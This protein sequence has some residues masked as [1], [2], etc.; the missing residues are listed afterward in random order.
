MLMED[1]FI[2][3]KHRGLE[4]V[5]GGAL[6]EDDIVY[7][8]HAQI[9]AGQET[10]YLG[11]L[12]A[13]TKHHVPMLPDLTDAEASALGLLAVRLSCALR[14]VAGAEHVYLFGIGDGVAHVHL[15]VVARYPGAPRDYYGPKVDEWP[16][17][18]HGGPDEIAA[19]C[20]RLRQ[21]LAAEHV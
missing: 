15:H 6:Y 18:P 19:L 14:A 8:G 17:A 13:E 4:T 5:P 3:R 11:Y 7:A 1:C 21:W 2:C 16:D 12:M 20:D 9:R 10:A